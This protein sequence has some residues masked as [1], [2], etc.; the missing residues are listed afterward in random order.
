LGDAQSEDP[1]T[2]KTYAKVTDLRSV[3]DGCYMVVYTWLYTRGEILADMET[4]AGIPEELR[5]NLNQRWPE[6]ADYDYMFSTNRTVTLWDTAICLAPDHVVSRIHD[7][8][9]YITRPSEC[10]ILDI[11]DFRVRWM[12][13]IVELEVPLTPPGSRGS[14]S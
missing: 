3:G 6:S 12:E 10:W 9:V 8:L 4:D 7:S 1:E 11:N 2:P 5:G 13:K 14:D